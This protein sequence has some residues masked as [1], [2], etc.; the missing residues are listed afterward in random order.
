MKNWKKWL[1]GLAALPFI[2]LPLIAQETA[3]EP[4][5]Q[6]PAAVPVVV[7]ELPAEVTDEL[8]EEERLADERLSI[9]KSLSFPVD[10]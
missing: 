7:D 4:A 3:P 10:I 9:D 8:S 2:G 6:V 5:A 1:W